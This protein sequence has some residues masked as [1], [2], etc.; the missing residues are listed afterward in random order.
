MKGS[1]SMKGM[2]GGGRREGGD[3]MQKMHERHR[4]EHD[5]MMQRQRREMDAAMKKQMKR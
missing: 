4:R 2:D 3:A 5:A 1:K